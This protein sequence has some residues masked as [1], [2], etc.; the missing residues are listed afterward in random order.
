MTTNKNNKYFKRFCEALAERGL[1]YEQ[2]QAEYKYSGGN[3]DFNDDMANE[4]SR[5]FNMCFPHDT[6]PERV[7]ECLCDHPIKNNCYISKDFDY[8]TILILGICCIKR[9]EITSARTCAHCNV[10][11]KNRTMNYCNGCK[12]YIKR[13]YTKKCLQCNTLNKCLSKTSKCEKCSKG[14]CMS[15][16]KKIDPKYKNCYGCNLIKK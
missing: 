5:Y 13:G 4:H 3:V 6:Q 7:F 1:T 9:F 16:S 14:S 8:D 10:P 11:H 12:E 2:V 15:C